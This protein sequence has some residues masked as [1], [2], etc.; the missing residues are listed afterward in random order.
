MC[1][2]PRR[3]RKA[4][5][6]HRS[7]IIFRYGTGRYIHPIDTDVRQSE[8]DNEHD[9]PSEIPSNIKYFEE[10]V[11]SADRFRVGNNGNSYIFIMCSRKL[12]NKSLY[13]ISDDII[14]N[15]ENIKIIRYN[16]III[17]LDYESI[18]FRSDVYKLLY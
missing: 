2:P 1:I 4:R 14:L 12:D 17:F 16:K 5:V 15:N 3:Y 9:I 18:I 8:N 11:C 7:N 6:P 13:R 10:T